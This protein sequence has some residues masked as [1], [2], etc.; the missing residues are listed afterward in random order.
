MKEM[1][2]DYELL[3]NL[4]ESSIAPNERKKFIKALDRLSGNGSFKE[5]FDMFNELID[6]MS[7]QA[8]ENYSFYSQGDEQL[9]S[10]WNYIEKQLEHISF[11]V[12]INIERMLEEIDKREEELE[13]ER[14]GL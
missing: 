10:S 8:N 6:T 1:S 5:N 13:D 9:Q 11:N 3:K 7:Y 2:K 4:I 14:E 12:L